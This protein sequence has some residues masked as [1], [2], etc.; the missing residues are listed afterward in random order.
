MAKK[1]KKISGK[2]TPLFNSMLVQNQA[3]KGEGLT[4]PPEPQPTPS[5]SQP[6]V[7]EPQTESLQ[8]ETPL[9]V[10]HELQ[11]EAHIEQILPSPSTYQRKQRKTQK[12]RR[13][14]K[15]IE[16]PQTSMPLNHEADE[17]VH[18]EGTTAMPNVDIPQEM[19]TGGSPR[20][21]ET[22]GGDLAQTR[23]ERVLEKPNEP[24]LS[25]GHTSGS[26]EGSMEHTF[27]MMDTV[28]PT[29]HDSPLSGGCIQTGRESDKTKSMFQDS[30]FDV[31]D[32]D[33]EYVKGETVH[34]ATTGV[35]TVSAPVT[36]VG[37]AISTAEPRTLPTTAATAFIDK[38]LII[39]Q[40]LIKMKEEKPRDRVSIKT[41]EF[42]E[43]QARIDADHELVKKER[44]KQLA[45]KRTEAI[46]N[47]PPTKTQLR[48]LMMTYLKNMGGYKHSHLKGK[49]YEE[50]QGLYER[51]QKRIQDFTPMDSVKE[52]QNPGKRLRRVTGSYATQ[53]SP[54]KP[55]VMKFAKDVTEEEAAEY[56]KEKEELRLSLKIISNDD[57]EVDYEPLSKKF[58]ILNSEYQLLG[59]MEAKD[60]Y[61]YKLTRADESSCYH[62]DTQAFLR[63]LNRQDLNDLYRLVHEWFQDH[64][65]EGH[66]L[67]LWGDL[68]M[69]FDPDEKDELWMNQLD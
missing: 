4:I 11:T 59:K 32:D 33:M 34:T 56:E 8:T 55:K 10:S 66:D 49:S 36:T 60:M 2:V 37:V 39:A 50:I 14:K 25:E 15:V 3:H 54:K 58:P 18:K 68:R 24:P 30:D 42:D 46:R 17:A 27:E 13:A 41:E 6:N 23:S 62:R 9:T 21:Q 12:H 38:D 26:G 61:V 52:A 69:I 63:R 67:L 57:S 35:S 1:S 22:I 16:L 19:D 53:K 64:P 43:I 65:L 40:T 28:I 45:V 48:N 47:K 5:T 44:K 7:S 20:S 31:L 51:Q 29:P